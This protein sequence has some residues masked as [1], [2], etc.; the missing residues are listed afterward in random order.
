MRFESVN[1][2]FL[3]R[4]PTVVTLILI[5]AITLF[6]DA[7]PQIHRVTG[8]AL[9]W[10]DYACVV[11]FVLEAS[12]KISTFGW[13]EYWRSGWN[14]FDFF[15]VLISL[16]SLLAPVLEVEAFSA[17][18]ILRLARLVR[19]FKML[20]FVPNG[21]RIMAGVS[22]ALQASVGVFIALFILNLLLAMG[23]TLLFGD[24][25]P[26]HFG[27]P[28]I[29]IYSLFKVFTVEGWYEI[30]DLL[31]ERSAS[32]A[33]ATL[34]RGYFV[35]AVVIGGLL[36]LSLANAVFVDEMTSDNTDRIEDMVKELRGEVKEVREIVERLSG[37]GAGP[38]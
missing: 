35:V 6:F 27:N 28:L 11:Y 30:P 22:R 10:I 5:N 17:I 26:E 23:A 7:F 9:G 34:L 2:H 15:V 13:R 31:A 29:S 37:H 3:I 8:G 25:A 20:R 1:P 36:G 14:R 19:F 33:W 32:G 18:L 4:E 24:L 16:P 38:R 21:P 12:L